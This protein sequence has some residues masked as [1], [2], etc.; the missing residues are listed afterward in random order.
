MRAGEAVITDATDERRSQWH[1]LT[2]RER[3]RLLTPVHE[4]WFVLT[5]L[6]GMRDRLRCPSCSAVG[7]WKMHGSLWERLFINRVPMVRRWLCK[8]CGYF[9]SQQG[10]VVAYLDMDKRVWTVPQPGE[11]R[12]PTPSEALSEVLPKAWPWLG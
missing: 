4:V 12:Q 11:E 7:T 5:Y 10:R 9:T 3:W 6:T 2:T 8:W 1:P